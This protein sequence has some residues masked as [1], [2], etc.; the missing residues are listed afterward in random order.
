[1]ASEWHSP[2]TNTVTVSFSDDNGHTT[3]SDD[4]LGGGKGGSEQLHVNHQPAARQWFHPS[5]RVELLKLGGIGSEI[6]GNTFMSE[7]LGPVSVM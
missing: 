6:C 1:M 3:H 4:G 2:G 7:T 5:T